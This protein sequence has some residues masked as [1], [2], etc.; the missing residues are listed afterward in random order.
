MVCGC[1]AF[2]GPELGCVKVVNPLFRPST[3]PKPE[4]RIA[5]YAKPKKSP[6]EKHFERVPSPEIKRFT[7]HRVNLPH[8]VSLFQGSVFRTG[9]LPKAERHFTFRPF[10]GRPP[11][12]P[13][14]LFPSGPPRPARRFPRT[15]VRPPTPSRNRSGIR[16][17][18]PGGCTALSK[19]AGPGRATAPPYP[20][21]TG[22]AR[23]GRPQSRA[24]RRL[25][26][27]FSAALACRTR[28][29]ARGGR[30]FSGRG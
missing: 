28:P 16:G 14:S 23:P 29:R 20:P 22:N 2:I 4:A 19:P 6:G 24:S 8:C 25:L 7:K 9:N 10:C 17:A 13:A 21:P 11:S 18:C 3:A 1:G 5:R 15:I 27:R 30:V 26:C 12:A